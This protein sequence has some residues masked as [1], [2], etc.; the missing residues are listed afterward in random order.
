MISEF[1][2]YNRTTIESIDPHEVPH[3]I[4][5]IRS[6]KDP[7]EARLPVGQ[8]TLGVLRLTFHDMDDAHMAY[9]AIRQEYEAQCF[10]RDQA[11]QIV[12]L[13]RSNPQAQRLLVHCDA[14]FS[15]SP[16]VAAALSKALTGDDRK[17]FMRYSPNMRVYRMLLEEYMGA[18]GA[19]D[20][21]H[22][23]RDQGR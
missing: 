20:G 13:V 6:P 11:R 17:F 3:V 14:G 7:N 21:D 5:S 15:R 2:V 19:N 23:H 10:S 22:D 8:H 4:V 12:T 9:P 18:A 1:I 16:A